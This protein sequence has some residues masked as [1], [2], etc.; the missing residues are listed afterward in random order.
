MLHKGKFIPYVSEADT[1]QFFDSLG[2]MQEIRQVSIG[3]VN[4]PVFTG[5]PSTTCN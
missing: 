4:D 3:K 5:N 2:L 1:I